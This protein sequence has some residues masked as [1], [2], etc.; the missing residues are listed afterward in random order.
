MPKQKDG[1]PTQEMNS[2]LTKRQAQILRLRSQRHSQQEVAEFLGTTRANISKLERR[3]HQNIMMARRT[4]HDWIKIQAPI[5]AFIPAG[6]E[7]LNVPAKI[8]RAADLEGM[9]LPVNC[10]DLVLQLKTMAPSLFNRQNLPRDVDIF[11]TC[12][13]QILLIEDRI[14]F[15]FQESE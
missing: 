10:I 14:K 1:D 11:I 2:F 4:I 5:I 13:G 6:T 9:H 7:V 12:E 3:A 15:S 8:F